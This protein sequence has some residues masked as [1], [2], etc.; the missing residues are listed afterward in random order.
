MKPLLNGIVSVAN[1]EL[2]NIKKPLCHSGDKC[3]F[4]NKKKLKKRFY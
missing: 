2:D 4:L 1:P 3:G